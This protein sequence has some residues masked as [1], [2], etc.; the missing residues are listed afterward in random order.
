MNVNANDIKGF[1]QTYRLHAIWISGSQPFANPN[2]KSPL[3]FVYTLE[4]FVYPMLS[5]ADVDVIENFKTDFVLQVIERTKMTIL[6]DSIGTLLWL[7][8]GLK[9]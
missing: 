5:I 9:I 6:I 2:K 4:L 1:F 8:Q 3:N 7:A